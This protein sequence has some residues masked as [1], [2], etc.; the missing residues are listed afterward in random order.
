MNTT[1][2]YYKGSILTENDYAEI[3]QEFR[4]PFPS[5]E[6]AVQQI[7]TKGEPLFS[8]YPTTIRENVRRFAACVSFAL[9][10]EPCLVVDGTQEAPESV[11]PPVVAPSE[12]EPIQT[13]TDATAASKKA[14]PAEQAFQ[15]VGENDDFEDESTEP[16]PLSERDE[17]TE[18][19]AVALMA[20]MTMNQGHFIITDDGVCVINPD[21]PPTLA[22]AYQVV[23]SV[24]KLEPLSGKIKSK[25][26]WML[27]SIVASLEDYFGEDFN[28]GQVCE[29]THK[30]ENTVRQAFSVYKKFKDKRYNVS[31]EHHRQAYHMK[32][33]FEVTCLL[34]SKAETY[35]FSA[36]NLR[37][38]GSICKKL[39]DDQVVRNIRSH[40]QGMDLI[41]AYKQAK[42]KY[43]CFEE[44]V[45]MEIVGLDGQLPK[46]SA[47][48]DADEHFPVVLDL[49]NKLAYANGVKQGEIV[50][51]G[52][53]KS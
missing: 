27:G 23:E 48:G 2:L 24:M 40:E 32:V 31:H 3:A 19:A 53:R 34:L 21:S 35:D 22:H 36:K 50:K 44:G 12:A 8:L 41:A 14:M 49:K 29:L 1:P 16:A 38:L 17:V 46:R 42:V 25:A 4:I 52:L 43:I 33:P 26:G 9:P 10:E 20:A 11:A 5:V 28:I 45:W 15:L 13:P 47:P 30:S 6:S 51:R 37:E 39:D 7:Q 18:S